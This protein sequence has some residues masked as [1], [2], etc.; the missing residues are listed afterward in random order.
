MAKEKR[1]FW[2]KWVWKHLMAGITVLAMSSA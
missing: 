1:A 2:R